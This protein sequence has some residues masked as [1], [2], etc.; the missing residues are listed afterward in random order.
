MVLSLA[1]TWSSTFDSP[2]P[3]DNTT[4]SPCRMTSDRPGMCSRASSRATKRPTE[5]S[6]AAV[7]TRCPASGRATPATAIDM[8]AR[9][10]ESRV[11]ALPADDH[12]GPGDDREHRHHRGK[13]CKTQMHERDD[14]R[15]DE[16]DPQQ[17][18]PQSL[19]H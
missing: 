3:R 15:Q 19:F 11:T 16:P 4:E 1:G 6:A 8:T 14:P 12:E 5:S 7:T 9:R 2:Q 13:S 18:M 17:Q 10:R